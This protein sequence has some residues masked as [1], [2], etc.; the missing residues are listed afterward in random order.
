MPLAGGQSLVQAMR[1]RTATPQAV[2]DVETGRVTVLK[3]WMVAGQIK[4]DVVQQLGGTP[5]EAY[6]YHA[7][8]R[9]R[10][11]TVKEYGMPTVWPAAEIEIHHLRTPSTIEAASGG[12]GFS[13]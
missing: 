1:L 13:G 6:D 5:Y 3:I 10:A 12:L 4:G 9:P 7:Q 2:V 11:N 8:G